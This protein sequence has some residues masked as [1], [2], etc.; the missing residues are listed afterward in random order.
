MEIIYGFLRKWNYLWISIGYLKTKVGNWF[1]EINSKL[2]E[3]DK[4]KVN[5]EKFESSV[6]E[7]KEIST[8]NSFT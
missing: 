7:I 5:V 1:K 2:L 8:S 6:Y 4:S 3:F